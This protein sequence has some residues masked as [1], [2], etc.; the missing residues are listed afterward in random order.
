MKNSYEHDGLA[1]EIL[2]ALALLDQ[3]GTNESIT[4]SIAIVYEG[5]RRHAAKLQFSASDL[6]MAIGD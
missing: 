2:E 6:L 1:T 5:F 3:K 4:Q